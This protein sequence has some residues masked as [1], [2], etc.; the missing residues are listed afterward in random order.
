MYAN[1][2]N[3]WILSLDVGGTKLLGLLID[4]SAEILVRRQE[5]SPKGNEAVTAAILQM[6]SD[7]LADAGVL[8]IQPAGIALCA[9]GFIDSQNGRV[10]I[11]ENL[12]IENLSLVRPVEGR[13]HLPTR[14]FHDVK[15]ATL[16][17]ALYGAGTGRQNFAFLNIGTGIAV[18]LY[19]D[20]KIYP[21]AQGIAGEVG[22]VALRPVGPGKPCGSDERLEALASGPGMV[23]RAAAARVQDPHSLIFELSGRTPGCVTTQIIQE[24]ALQGD[25]LAVHLIEE[26]ADYLGLVIGNILDLLDL[27][28]VILGGGVAQMGELLLKPVQQSVARYAITPVPLQISPLG[29][30]VG[31]IGAAAFY[32][33]SG[34]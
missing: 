32:F 29:G 8:E 22:H 20:G 33:C 17:E 28:C 5:P 18:G 4:R 26:T 27:E 1:E 34:G 11:N 15:S 6:C 23:R 12:Q 30:S 9:P 16:A 25:A 24:A 21:G 7:L 10:I 31:A 2:N 13:F 3:E 14:L 19:L